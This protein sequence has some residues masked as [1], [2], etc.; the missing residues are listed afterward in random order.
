MI[1]SESSIF[2]F[3]ENV[4]AC[5]HCWT[6]CSFLCLCSPFAPQPY[7]KSASRTCLHASRPRIST[8]SDCCPTPRWHLCQ[9]RRDCDSAH[10]GVQRISRRPQCH[11]HRLTTFLQVRR[12]IPRQHQYPHHYSCSNC[13]SGRRRGLVSASRK[14]YTRV[15]IVR[16]AVTPNRAFLPCTSF[17][18]NNIPIRRLM[19]IVPLA[20][21][22]RRRVEFDALVVSGRPEQHSQNKQQWQKERRIHEWSESSEI[23]ILCSRA[24]EC[25][26]KRI[27]LQMK[28]WCEKAR[29]KN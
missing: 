22:G 18:Q 10:R 14:K 6:R 16:P 2:Y 9:R 4:S 24:H 28:K 25:S 19:S 26:A 7:I 12:G 8:C 13:Q 20:G 21:L 23:L 1:N 17:W 15:Y 29:K 11:G 5:C 27:F 3:F